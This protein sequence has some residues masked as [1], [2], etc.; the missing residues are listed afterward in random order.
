[1]TNKNWPD[2]SRIL[3]VR[4]D[5]LGDV[6]M[7]TPAF[8]AM[9]SAWPNCQL[10][11]LTSS[12]GAGVG[13]YV[14]AIDAVIRFDVPWVQGGDNEPEAIV[15]MANELK[16]QHFDAAVVFTVQS[17]NPLPAAMLCY[18]AGIPKV[19]GYCRENPYQ[20][21]TNWVPDPEVLVATR[22]EV[23]RQL[24][25][26]ETVGCQR[27]NDLRLQLRIE[28]NDRQ[29]ARELLERYGLDAA[30][31]WLILH[32][33]VSEAKRRYPADQFAAVART[34][35]D[36]HDYQLVLT[37]TADEYELAES[38]RRKLGGRAINVAG[39][40]SLG[41]FIALVADAP[42][43]LS[44]NTGPVHIAA[45]VQT[46]VVVVYA[47]TNPQH[48]PWNVPSQVLYTNVPSEL[49]SRNVL[50][51]HFPEPAEPMASPEA[52]VEAVLRLATSSLS[53]ACG[54]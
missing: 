31:P 37:G 41:Q 15:D 24:A 21:M 35:I 1:M 50:L 54:A 14:P 3:C 30:R 9:K 36:E 5:N 53:L 48:T 19:L 13:R 39:G 4:L 43:L 7:T 46:P 45:A 12:A 25:L 42:V 27:P 32:P 2:G 17:Q 40:L 18:L 33:G 10:T 52:I 38:I 22:H 49:R 34:L 20:L 51:Q 28:E 16:K 29:T 26:V 8:Q 47:K 23:D 11:L 44:N 6:L